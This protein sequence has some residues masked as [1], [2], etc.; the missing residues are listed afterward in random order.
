MNETCVMKIPSATGSIPWAV[1]LPLFLFLVTANGKSDTPPTV[2]VSGVGDSGTRGMVE[3]LRR[4]GTVHMC[5][6]GQSKQLDC[7]TTK[8]CQDH[9]SQLLSKTKADVTSKLNETKMRKADDAAFHETVRCE[10][11]K[12][13]FIHNHSNFSATATT[14]VNEQKRLWGYKNPRHAY[15][16]PAIAHA[17]RNDT[18]QLVV[19]RHPYDV[20]SGHNRRQFTDFGRYFNATNNCVAFWANMHRNLFHLATSGDP[21]VRMKMVRIE[22]F[23]LGTPAQRQSVG[24]CVAKFVGWEFDQQA[25]AAAAADMA[26]FNS[27]YGGRARLEKDA[28]HKLVAKAIS[29]TDENVA[30][31]AAWFGYGLSKYGRWDHLDTQYLMPPE[32][33]AVVCA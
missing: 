22:S 15:I 28:S 5:D 1:L 13:Q 24:R 26:V 3:Y 19:V 8:P 16:A 29:Q 12:S 31:V 11:E 17:F 30:E 14:N 10:K 33:E 6:R 21:T 18:A 4:A 9:I 23:T 2:I 25:S 27:S 20:C 32:L 7:D